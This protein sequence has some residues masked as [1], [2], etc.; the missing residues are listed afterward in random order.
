MHHVTRHPYWPVASAPY[1]SKAL[2]RDTMQ[3]REMHMYTYATCQMTSLCQ[4]SLQPLHQ[5]P[6][7]SD[8]QAKNPQIFIIAMCSRPFSLDGSQALKKNYSFIEI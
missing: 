8:P 2:D 5:S 6:E 7:V 1:Q 4:G 3:P